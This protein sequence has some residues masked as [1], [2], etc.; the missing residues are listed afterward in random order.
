[1]KNKLIYISYDDK[2]VS[3]NEQE[4]IEYEDK[5]LERN[6]VYKNADHSLLIFKVDNENF[7]DHCLVEELGCGYTEWIEF[8]NYVVVEI[9]RGRIISLKTYRE[10]GLFRDEIADFKGG[11]F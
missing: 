6:L 7:A 3:D 4:I 1:M 10:S 11:K 2:L 9:Y 8:P 5:A